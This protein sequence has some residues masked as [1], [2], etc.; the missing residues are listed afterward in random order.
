[1]LRE[2]MEEGGHVLAHDL[3]HAAESYRA[4]FLLPTLGDA[5]LGEPENILDVRGVGRH[6]RESGAGIRIC[7]LIRI[8]ERPSFA[9][10]DENH[11][12]IILVAAVYDRVVLKRDSN[13]TVS[14]N[15]TKLTGLRVAGIAPIGTHAADG[16]VNIGPIT[17]RVHNKR[18]RKLILSD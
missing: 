11:R 16:V 17:R 13:L 8:Q 2:P 3:A 7:R 12:A 4:V 18:K 5:G 10:P 1:M 14:V 6:I 9:S 15:G